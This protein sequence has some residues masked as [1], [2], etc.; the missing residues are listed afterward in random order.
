MQVLHL[1]LTKVVQQESQ[2]SHLAEIPLWFLL[3]LR[4]QRA[5]IFLPQSLHLMLKIQSASPVA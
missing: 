3:I 2:R 1:I 4:G 5:L